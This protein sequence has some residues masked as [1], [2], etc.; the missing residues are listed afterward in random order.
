MIMQLKKTTFLILI[1][2]LLMLNPVY[3]QQ[4][5]ITV[6]GKVA[7]EFNRPIAG[8]HVYSKE[9]RLG[10]VTDK[11]GAFKLRMKPIPVKFTCTH[12]GFFESGV[13]ITKKQ[14][15]NRKSDT[16]FVE[17]SMAMRTMELDAISINASGIESV[18]YR[19]EIKLIDYEFWMNRLLL[20]IKVD[21]KYRIRMLDFDYNT[22]AQLEFP[23]KLDKFYRNAF[24]GVH[25]FAEDTVYQL[26]LKP[27]NIELLDV[28]S[29]TKF[30][31]FVKSCVVATDSLLVFSAMA[32][33]NQ[34]QL[35][36]TINR[37][38]K[39]KKNL[40]H[41]FD[42]IGA[43][44]AQSYYTEITGS[45]RRTAPKLLEEG[46]IEQSIVASRANFELSQWYRMVS[47]PVCAPIFESK[48]EIVLFDHVNDSLF[49]YDVNGKRIE[50]V[51]LSYHKLRK[52][53][54]RIISDFN[55]N[56]FAVFEKIGIMYLNKID[57]KSGEIISVTKIARHA[58][59]QNLKIRDGYAYYMY[60]D[61]VY[62]Y[63]HKYRTQ[64]YRQKIN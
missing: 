29:K 61:R 14:I 55:G 19:P 44:Y 24:G 16:I 40:H 18:F 34:E 41:V 11:Y 37:N 49:K 33:H 25:V 26:Y 12:I 39:E 7:D 38:T 4:E 52:W 56:Y 6:I 17:I 36:Y 31:E 32:N 9:K 45:S 59:P 50:A 43:K 47:K 27:D 22:I 20:L 10:K 21:K 13:S 46:G 35:Y 15:V 51:P 8:A 2:F 53:K 57:M 42:E 60:T 48:N 28:A 58:Y 30:I 62:P 54:E 23:W 1:S 5:I 63:I 64:L 3:S